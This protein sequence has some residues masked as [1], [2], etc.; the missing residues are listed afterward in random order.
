MTV[1]LYFAGS[2]DFSTQS[3]FG[4]S[5]LRA[6]DHDHRRGQEQALHQCHQCPREGTDSKSI[7]FCFPILLVRSSPFIK[8]EM[9]CFCFGL[10]MSRREFYSLS[11]HLYGTI[12]RGP[13]IP[14]SVS[15]S[16]IF[17]IKYGSLRQKQSI[18]FPGKIPRDQGYPDPPPLGINN[19]SLQS[20][21]FA[22]GI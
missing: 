14:V 6:P 11:S 7:C 18:L 1:F 4:M 13:K 15:L 9:C 3:S 19:E 22:G 20:P 12:F 21:T 5:F 8:I 10:K 17:Y 16:T 2:F